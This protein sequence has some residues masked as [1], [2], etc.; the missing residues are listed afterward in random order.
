MG[1]DMIIVMPPLFEDDLRLFQRMERLGVQALIPQATVEALII[2][3]L[4]RTAG[5]DIP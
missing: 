3:I 2:S 4:P 5:L 1:A